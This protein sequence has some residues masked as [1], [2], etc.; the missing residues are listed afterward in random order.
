MDFEVVVDV[1][2]FDVV[3]RLSRINSNFF[4][5]IQINK[6]RVVDGIIVQHCR[7]GKARAALEEGGATRVITYTN[8]RWILYTPKQA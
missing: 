8:G 7:G 3:A 6:F 4:G 5:S 2:S 1:M